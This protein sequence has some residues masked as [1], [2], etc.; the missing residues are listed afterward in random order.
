MRLTVA[1]SGTVA[2]SPERAAP[3]HWLDT[4]RHRIL[5][6]C[7]GG[8]LLRASQHGLPWWDVDTI[9]ITHFHP[10][11]LTEL[12]LL[13]Y[14]FRW[15]REPPRSRQVT[16]IGPQGLRTRVD[17]MAEI[18]GAAVREPDFGLRVIELDPGVPFDLGN[19]AELEAHDTPHTKE[20]MAYSVRSGGARF[21]YTGDTG[22]S[23]ELADWASGA[24]L[25]LAECSLP[26]ERAI[27]VHLT[28]GDAGRLAAR[29]EAGELVLTHCY[30][31]LAAVDVIREVGEVFPGP[32]RL[33]ND[34]DS[35]D[36][37]SIP[38]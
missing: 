37:G 27:D 30:P 33:A 31:P 11:H 34:G 19:G 1:G 38:C 23:E 36:I 15:G 5:F 18:F 28:P 21:V 6:D 12:P 26:K 2:P 17:K 7:G 16:L 13:M 10:D 29:A 24:D 8:F 25:L 35:F 22:P 14:A 32:V 3:S 20:S 4:G 9:A